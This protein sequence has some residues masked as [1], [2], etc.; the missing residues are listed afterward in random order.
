LLQML[1]QSAYHI[2]SHRVLTRKREAE[3]HF[4]SFRGCR[5]TRP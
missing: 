1:V 3:L 4:F 2:V 5:P